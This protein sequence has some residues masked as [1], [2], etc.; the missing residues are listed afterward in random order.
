MQKF[1]HQKANATLTGL[2]EL[3]VYGLMGVAAYLAHAERVGADVKQLHADLQ[4]QM[5]FHC[6][7][8]A[9]QVDTVLAACL[10]VGELNVR[11][12][13]ALDAAHTS[14]CDPLPR[15]NLPCFCSVLNHNQAPPIPPSG[16]CKRFW[17]PVI[18]PSPI[19]TIS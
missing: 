14:M 2:Q 12:M 18:F 16:L 3:H 15:Y 8:G 7:M 9:E 6:T 4:K 13:A 1:V 17:L 5:A 19:R 11:V 10:E